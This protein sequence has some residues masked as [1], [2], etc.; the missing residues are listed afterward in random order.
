MKVLIADD[1]A[2]IRDSMALYVRQMN[3]VEAHT[4]EDFLS[5]KAMVRVGGPFDLVVL[6]FNMPNMNGLDGVSEMLSEENCKRVA[7]LSG[8]ATLDEARAGIE[9]GASGFLSKSL[10][11][12]EFQA[13]VR[14]M[15]EGGVFE[16]QGKDLIQGI[17]N[18]RHPKLRSLNSREDAVLAGIVKGLTNRQIGEEMGV[19]EVTVKLYTKGL[20][21]KL[22]VANRPAA[23]SL[24]R[25]L[26]VG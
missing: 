24:A 6:D 16:P 2:L 14:T 22:G 13:A 21:Q 26:G 19:A 25:D 3:G 12:E 18:G 7:L 5:A 17:E 10:S 9:V 15:L 1:H 8:V 23:A 4:A 11:V 20:F